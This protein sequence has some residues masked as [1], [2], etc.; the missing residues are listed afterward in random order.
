MSSDLE[1]TLE[2][3]EANFE[4]EVQFLAALVQTPSIH[5]HTE[6]EE[7]CQ[8]L[9]EEH[10]AHLGLRTDRFIPDWD[11]LNDFR[12]PISGESLYVKSELTRPDYLANRDRSN[13]VST[14]PAARPGG[15]SLLFNG[16]I[17]VVPEGD[18]SRWTDP[19]FSGIVRAG[20][21]FGRGAS[22]QKAG[23]AAMIYALQAVI[24]AGVELAGDVILET[25]VDEETGGNGTL[26]CVHRGYRADAAVFTEPTDGRAYYAHVGGQLYD[27]SVRGQ[28]AHPSQGKGVDAIALMVALIQKTREW[29]AARSERLREEARRRGSDFANLE[30]PARISI[31]TIHGGQ[32]MSIAAETVT[33][34]GG[35]RIVPWQ[36]AASL[37]AEYEAMLA[38][39]AEEIPWLRQQPVIVDWGLNFPGSEIPPDSPIVTSIKGAAER[40]IG[41][42]LV[43]T[44]L[45]AGCDVW[46][47]NRVA[48]TPT[49][50]YGPG[51]MALGHGPDESVALDDVRQA[52]RTMA[53]LILD[54]CR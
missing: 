7:R 28:A 3:V 54:W 39:M 1:R 45:N 8:D 20:R 10:L 51:E 32:F 43:A 30:T 21:L 6:E 40:G 44:V 5:L 34:Q 18:I 22:D 26:A 38:Q 23:V 27:I 37:R 31:N 47:Y 48:Q 52:T 46:I 15:R 33:I 17:D 25:V 12:D 41:Q 53:A 19:P 13:L 14:W 42:P 29:E 4:D 9:I 36:T 2:R 11:A 49:I 50:L 35:M 24:E 16:H